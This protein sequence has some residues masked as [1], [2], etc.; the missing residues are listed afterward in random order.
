MNHFSKDRGTESFV[1][2]KDQSS[3]HLF[4]LIPYSDIEFI[5]QE[6]HIFLNTRSQIYIYYSF[7]KT[8]LNTTFKKRLIR[9]VIVVLKRKQQHTIFSIKNERLILLSKMRMKNI[10]NLDKEEFIITWILLYG[11]LSLDDATDTFFI[12]SKTEYTSNKTFSRS[13]F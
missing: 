11:D 7:S 10:D 1:I 8:N 9:F 13:S 5:G 4:N 3:A 2:Y 6:M 12:T